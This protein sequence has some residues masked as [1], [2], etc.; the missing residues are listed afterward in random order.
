MLSYIY[1]KIIGARF[2][3]S[4][5]DDSEYFTTRD[6][7]GHGTHTSSTAAG[8]AVENASYYGVA[9]GTA[10]GGSPN[11]RIAMYKV[12]NPGGCAGSSI[13]AAFDDAIA[14]G[15][16][17]LSLSLGAPSYARIELNTDPIAIGAF[18]AVEQ[19]ILVVC[20]AGNDGPS[21]GTVVNTA[22]WIMTVAANTIDRD[23]ESDV[24]LG[25][26]KVIKVKKS[27]TYRDIIILL[28]YTENKNIECSVLLIY[29]FFREK[30]YTLGMLASLL[31][32][33]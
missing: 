8:S 1:R 15:V 30:A 16:D 26:N 6:V 5:E 22:P 21:D 31:Y 11:A 29:F 17:V 32:I 4:P 3:K 10:K 13:L 12:C 2:Y 33:L 9:S 23:L 18:H 27:Q 24:V 19:G 20:S 14:D 7:I 25:G 28:L